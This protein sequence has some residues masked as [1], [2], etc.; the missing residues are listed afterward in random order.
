MLSESGLNASGCDDESG[1]EV[2]SAKASRE[3]PVVFRLFRLREDGEKRETSQLI[4]KD[5]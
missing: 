1:E 5:I 2:G 3:R 4:G